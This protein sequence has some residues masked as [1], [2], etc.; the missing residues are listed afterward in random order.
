M[1]LYDWIGQS[2]RDAEKSKDGG[3]PIVAHRKNNADWLVTM[4]AEDWFKI[5]RE[6]EAGQ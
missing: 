3:I 4:R 2:I 5:Y 6:W 1:H